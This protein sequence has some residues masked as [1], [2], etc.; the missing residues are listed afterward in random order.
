[1]FQ[2]FNSKV[3][4]NWISKFEIWLYLETFAIDAEREPAPNLGTPEFNYW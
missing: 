4:R 3:T 2:E 1:M